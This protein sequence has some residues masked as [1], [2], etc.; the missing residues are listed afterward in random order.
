MGDAT[1]WLGDELLTG[2][3]PSTT[4]TAGLDTPS[5]F[6]A[7]RTDDRPLRPHRE[8]RMVWRLFV[9]DGANQNTF[10]VL[11]GRGKVT[12][13]RNQRHADLILNDL[14]VAHAHCHIEVDE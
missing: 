11:P 7:A 12:L 14:Y 3:A 13:G 4:I 1:P 10:F 6:P 9:S 5:Q 2:P 8:M